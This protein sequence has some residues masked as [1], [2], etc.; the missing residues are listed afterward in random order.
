MYLKRYT[1]KEIAEELGLNENTVRT[2]IMRL[3]ARI[4]G[5][6]KRGVE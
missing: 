2:Q 5:R 4:R 1:A 6:Y 3:K